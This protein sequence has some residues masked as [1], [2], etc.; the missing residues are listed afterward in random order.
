MFDAIEYINTPRWQQSRLGLERIRDLL[1][2]LGRPQDKL[3]FVHVAGTNGKGSTC[4]YL[5]AV[6]RQAG[7]KTGLF[8]SP[9]IECFEERIRV[10]GQ[11][12]SAADLTCVTLQVK[13]QAEALFA[14]TGD[15]PT[16]FELM[17]AVALV[18]FALSGCDICVLEVGLGGRLDSTN[19]IEKPEVSV[20]CRLG[21]DHTA[22]LG[23]T[24]E[25]I[26]AEKAGIV[27]PGCPVVTYPQDPEAQAV[28]ERV[29]KEQGC[30][31]SVARL[32]DEPI[33][34]LSSL[35]QRFCFDGKPYE[36]QLLAAYQP[37][38]AAV[39][40]EALKVMRS[41]GWDISD[42]A[43]QAGIAQAQW[44]GRFELLDTRPRSVVDGGHNPQGALALRDTLEQWLP[45]FRQ[46]GVSGPVVFLVGLLADKD[47]PSMLK[48][49]VPM[50]D[51]LVATQPRNPR[52][53]GAANLAC[54][55]EKL[56]KAPVKV[57]P[58]AGDA[59]AQA[60]ALAGEDGLVVA[61][62][63]LYQVGEIKRCL[64]G[65]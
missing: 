56:T 47:Y 15:H 33:N 39:A 29:A 7:Y 9:Y 17:T 32:D 25:K 3:K 12:I 21:L 11:N 35:R 44:P 42:E 23:D 49:V 4:A 43:L 63:S 26:A 54:E 22:I 24:L 2:R 36:T 10:D 40:L 52:A 46:S 55:L 30:T 13:E 31:L 50:A 28:L 41:A 8:T 62:G 58:Q 53:L 19:V 65:E 51:A 16:E 27:K 18:H 59:A 60:C 37:S 57:C 6:L 61:F 5:D 34:L 20:I 14:Q 48:T 64:L 38:N 45:I 1:D